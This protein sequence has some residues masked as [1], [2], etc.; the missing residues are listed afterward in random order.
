MSNQIGT[1]LNEPGTGDAAENTQSREDLANK[2]NLAETG[3]SVFSSVF[4]GLRGSSSVQALQGLQDNYT[5]IRTGAIIEMANIKALK[6]RTTAFK[7][8]GS[9]VAGAGKRGVAAKGSVIDTLGDMVM[10]GELQALEIERNAELGV[11]ALLAQN[12][13][14]K[15]KSEL[16]SQNS[17]FGGAIGGLGGSIKGALNAAQIAQA[18]GGTFGG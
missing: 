12:E 9:F 1:A 17:L 16:Q 7:K 10:E 14:N 15:T 6:A 8:Q 4:S 11:E 3:L 18:F 2:L 13:I 5:D